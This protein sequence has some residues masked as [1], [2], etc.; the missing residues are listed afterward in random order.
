MLQLEPTSRF[1]LCFLRGQVWA[2]QDIWSI[3]VRDISEYLKSS[4]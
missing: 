1:S 4:R 2:A 3:I